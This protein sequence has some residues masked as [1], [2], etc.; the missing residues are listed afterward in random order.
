MVLGL[1]LDAF[2]MLHV[3]I[4]LVGIASG[5]VVA[6]G[7]VSSKDRI[8][9]TGLFLSTTMLTSLTGFL[10]PFNGF[11]PSHAFGII[12]VVVLAIALF[13][14]Y[15]R[16]LSGV[17]RWIYITC[18]LIAL[19]LNMF[20]GVVQSFQKIA[21]LQPLAPTQSELPFAVAQ[22]GLLIAFLVLGYFSITRFR[23]TVA[24]QGPAGP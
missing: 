8:F 9:W 21:F 22:I 23:P 16:H 18:A 4:S 19:Y 24:A 10:F 7:M 1:S 17:W 11:L 12:S 6:Y 20:V 5:I 14:L 13:A 2:T 3:I 15:S